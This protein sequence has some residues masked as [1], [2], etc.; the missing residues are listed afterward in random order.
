VSDIRLRVRHPG[1]GNCTYVVRDS[2]G[3]IN[4]LTSQRIPLALSNLLQEQ[5]AETAFRLEDATSAKEACDILSKIL[6][7][8]YRNNPGSQPKVETL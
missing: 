5:T 7:H 4:Y 2:R 3:N 8:I 1:N 6:A